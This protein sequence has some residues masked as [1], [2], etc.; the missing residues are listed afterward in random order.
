MTTAPWRGAARTAPWPEPVR[1]N[2]LA[3]IQLVGDVQTEWETTRPNSNPYQN[4]TYDAIGRDIQSGAI[5]RP[6]DAMFQMGDISDGDAG[7]N[8]TL[9][10]QRFALYSQW[11]GDYN[12]SMYKI[13]G[14]H[15]VP[16]GGL[17]PA[18]WCTYWGLPSPHYAVTV[19]GVRVYVLNPDSEVVPAGW[20]AC[21][22]T[23]PTLPI[24]ASQIQWL[25]QQLTLDS[26]PAIVMSHAPFNF[27]PRIVSNVWYSAFS[28]RAYK[29]LATDLLNVLDAH[30][31][32]IGWAHGHTHG[33]YL[34]PTHPLSGPMSVGNRTIARVDA[35]ACYTQPPG[36]GIGRP[37]TFYVSVL[38]DGKTIQVRSRD[39][40]RKLWASIPTKGP[41]NTVVAT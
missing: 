41:V 13:M 23:T 5:G 38:D 32:V 6:P 26:R 16:T 19:G 31:Q 30:P 11:C 17:T 15:D 12:L 9:L 40:H 36:F 8:A 7:L 35:G 2:S 37:V 22:H 27:E 1:A 3:T 28:S 33:D 14:N 29:L 34:D 18:Q 4:T 20:E 25:D 39:H 10:K 21:P 24:S